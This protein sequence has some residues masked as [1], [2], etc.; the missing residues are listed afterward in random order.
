[1]TNATKR[2]EAA[3]ERK[4]KEEERKAA[5]EKAKQEAEQKSSELVQELSDL[6]DGAE[7]NVEA[8]KG[9]ND[10]LDKAADFTLDDVLAFTKSVQGAITEAKGSLKSCNDF[11]GQ[12]GTAMNKAIS[13]EVAKERQE[14]LTKLVDRIGEAQKAVEQAVKELAANSA[15]AMK[16]VEAKALTDAM[17]SVFKKFDKDKDKFLSKA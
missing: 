1:M 8:L 17:E 6:V 9:E 11:I 16:K 15:V 10:K 5:A 14:K 2:V 13:P 4:R 3:L 7:A 12:N